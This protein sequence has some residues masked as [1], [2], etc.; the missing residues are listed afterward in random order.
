MR[1]KIH[2]LWSC[3]HNEVSS[4]MKVD[5]RVGQ[6]SNSQQIYLK[7]A[8]FKTAKLSKCE[9]GGILPDPACK[10]GQGRGTKITCRDVSF[11]FFVWSCKALLFYHCQSQ[12][13]QGFSFPISTSVVIYFWQLYYNASSYKS[14]IFFQEAGQISQN[15]ILRLKRARRGHYKREG[16]H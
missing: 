4:K 15:W 12:K 16:K 1:R 2:F 13:K 10:K 3:S 6:S 9:E 7:A 5:R 14:T 11:K 8:P